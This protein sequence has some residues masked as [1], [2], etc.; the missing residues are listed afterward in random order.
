MSRLSFEIEAIDSFTADLRK[1]Q[2]S[3]YKKDSRGREEFAAL[4]ERALE[5][6][7]NDPYATRYPNQV[8]GNTERFPP[9]YARDDCLLRK[10][11]FALPRTRGATAFGRIIFRVHTEDRVICLL[12]FYTHQAHAGN[13]PQAGLAKRLSEAE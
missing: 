7:R 8:S 6:V 10:L 11:R 3:I 5:A 4:I 13:F 2:K 12:A 9:G 1:A